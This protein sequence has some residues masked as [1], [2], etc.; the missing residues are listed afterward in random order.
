MASRVEAA[1]AKEQSLR[2]VERVSP[3]TE[4]GTERWPEVRRIPP[5]PVS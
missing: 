4:E 2:V 5:N 3:A 1:A